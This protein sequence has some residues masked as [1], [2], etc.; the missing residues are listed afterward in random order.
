MWTP[1]DR[2]VGL[3]KEDDVETLD[4]PPF[5]TVTR[6]MDQTEVRDNLTDVTERMEANRRERDFLAMRMSK[7]DAEYYEMAAEKVG[8]LHELE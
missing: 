8:W 7:L 1:R 6:Y 4:G 2:W 5:E 3:S